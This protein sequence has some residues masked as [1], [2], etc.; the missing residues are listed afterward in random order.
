MKLSRKRHI[1]CYCLG[2]VASI[3]EKVGSNIVKKYEQ[4]I[5]ASS[6]KRYCNLAFPF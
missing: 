2:K 4:S 5:A 6:V 1:C 3:D